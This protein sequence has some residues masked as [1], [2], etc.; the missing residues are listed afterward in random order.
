M[1]MGMM[2]LVVKILMM[3]VEMKVDLIVIIPMMMLVMLVIIM[4]LMMAGIMMRWIVVIR[5]LNFTIFTLETAR[6][7]LIFVITILV[8]VLV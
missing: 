6:T 5:I 8:V 4:K 2:I 1:K 7:K 3:L